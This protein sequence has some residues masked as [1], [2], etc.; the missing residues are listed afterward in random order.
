MRATT[1]IFGFALM[2]LLP[3]SAQAQM[4]N[5]DS[6]LFVVE[7]SWEDTAVANAY[8][9]L[10]SL[11]YKN[12]VAKGNEYWELAI[13]RA[14]QGLAKN[15]PAERDALLRAKARAISGLGVIQ[16]R[17]A[18]YTEALEFYHESLSISEVL[19]DPG[20]KSTT[21]FNLS[22][23]YRKLDSI[24]TALEYQYKCLAIR[25][26]NDYKKEGLMNCYNALGI[27]HRRS[28]NL[29]SA[30]YYYEQALELNLELKNAENTAQSYANLGVVRSREGAYND[31][32]IYFR[33][34]LKIAEEN[35]LEHPAH[36]MHLSL[37]KQFEYLARESKSPVEAQSLLDSAIAHGRYAFKS[38]EKSGR[39]A[40]LYKAAL[41]LSKIFERRGELDS[42]LAYHRT[43]AKIK[44][45]L[46]N[47]D[48]N[49]KFALLQQKSTFDEIQREREAQE[50]KAQIE[51]DEEAK[52]DALVRNYLL[53][54]GALLLILAIVLFRAYRGKSKSNEQLARQKEQIEEQKEL[55]EEKNQEI[56]D[57]INY[58][59]R[60]QD[61]ILPSS[62]VLKHWF[63]ESSVLY[64]P[65]DIVAGDFYWVETVDDELY[66][67]VGDCTGHGVPGAM[68]TVV[69]STALHQSVNEHGLRS[70]A[71]I[72][73]KVTDIV[74][75]RFRSTEDGQEVK[76]GMDI[77]LCKYD[78]KSK[79][80]TFAGAKNPL[81]IST[82]LGA[83][84]PEL[85]VVKVSNDIRQLLEIKGSRQPVGHV[86]EREPFTEF[87]YECESGDSLFLFTDGMPDQF[88]GENGKKMKYKPFKQMLLESEK[89]DLT[90]CAAQLEARLVKWRGEL[91]QVDDVCVMS[92][93]I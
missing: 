35:N 77:A 17:F 47:E 24:P 50:A 53:G 78:S 76:D 22:T 58:A 75:S 69:C 68:L 8:N 51:R 12:D 30:V 36:N 92:I 72:L 45:A 87:S 70:P 73:D 52:R 85:A 56:V 21:Y 42:A 88:G 59:K 26:A 64:L 55:V 89:G 2:V 44:N 62:E 13:E 38:F 91:E 1:V 79:T 41:S 61:A 57:S 90:A 5:A 48:E 54:L 46:I 81:Y 20:L 34:S 18:N 33:K 19:E 23:L 11:C 32:I 15:D 25:H 37:C 82:R 28:N 63:Q 84:I 16:R 49:K 14:D 31:A 3:R 39:R 9:E 67:A 86:A 93:R 66:F 83:E 10:A 80:V 71:R 74:T 60:L 27:L 6:L 29:D 43:Y 40:H 4:L 7:N 65:K